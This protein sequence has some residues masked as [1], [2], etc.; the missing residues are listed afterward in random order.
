MQEKGTRADM[1][2][3]YLKPAL[4]RSN[5]Q[6][7]GGAGTAGRSWMHVRVFW[8]GAMAAATAATGGRQP[9]ASHSKRSAGRDPGHSAAC[10]TLS[11]RRN[12]CVGTHLPC[13]C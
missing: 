3:Q 2:R 11:G 10:Y 6:V 9:A 5:L 12:A 4:G 8:T 1:Y 13:R 7:R